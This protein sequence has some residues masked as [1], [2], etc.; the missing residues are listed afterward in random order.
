MSY[1][2]AKQVMVMCLWDDVA[3][4]SEIAVSD[5]VGLVY[6]IHQ[7]IGTEVRGRML[8]D[9][10]LQDAIGRISRFGASVVTVEGDIASYPGMLKTIIRIMEE[11]EPEECQIQLLFSYGSP[12]YI[13]A[14]AI[15]ASVSRTVDL[16]SMSVDGSGDTVRHVYPIF[17]SSP[18]E[19]NHVRCLKI[20]SDLSDLGKPV[21][22]KILIKAIKAENLWLYEP[23]KL[24]G[25]GIVQKEYM[26]CKRHYID[27]W[28][29][30]GWIFPA[31]LSGKPRM[32]ETGKSIID[33]FYTESE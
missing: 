13:A 29:T 27:S 9:E 32:T 26:Y 31:D 21:T 14:T 8:Q 18:P 17:L 3:E 1:D 28:I 15:C 5:D 30:K 6:I 19:E 16:V 7:A 10:V 22:V 20:F 12:E 33:I 23:S 4:M 11:L 24:S 25:R 2:N